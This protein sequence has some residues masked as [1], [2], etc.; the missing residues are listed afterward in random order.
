RWRFQW[1]IEGVGG[2]DVGPFRPV[3]GIDVQQQE[4]RSF[5]PDFSARLGLQLDSPTAAGANI[6]LMLEYY[7]GREVNGQ[8]WRD[9][10][11]YFG[12]GFHI[13]L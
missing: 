6:R 10:L 5:T 2:Q 11:Q 9:D 12:V 3:F 7:N 8:F 13:L 1:G 4:G